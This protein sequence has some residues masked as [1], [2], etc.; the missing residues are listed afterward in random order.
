MAAQFQVRHLLLS[1]TQAARHTPSPQHTGLN[2]NTPSNASRWER[3]QSSHFF[4][5]F[6][7][8]S[9]S[10][11]PC[12]QCSSLLCVSDGSSTCSVPSKHTQ[13]HTYARLNTRFRNVLLCALFSI[14]ECKQHFLDAST[15]SSSACLCQRTL[16]HR[17][18][19]ILGYQVCLICLLES[20]MAFR[21]IK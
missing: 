20:A 2:P 13:T 19:L 12:S 11:L 16:E 15:P 17:S 6:F 1:D 3:L 4:D 21:G 14:Y 8:P 5:D 18:V 10:A 7:S 9:L